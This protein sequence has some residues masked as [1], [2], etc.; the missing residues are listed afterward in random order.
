MAY[1]LLLQS[2]SGINILKPHHL[3]SPPPLLP[4]S[5]LAAPANTLVSPCLELMKAIVLAES[6]LNFNFYQALSAPAMPTYM[7]Q[8]GVTLVPSF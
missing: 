4:F 1:Q 6:S 8:V 2:S 7:I 5:P 3:A